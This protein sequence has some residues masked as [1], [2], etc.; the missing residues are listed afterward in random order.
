MDIGGEITMKKMLAVLASPRKNGNASKMLDIAVQKA[1]KCGYDVDYINLYDKNLAYCKG[2]MSCKKTAA[3]IIN[4]DIKE[5]ENQIKC[6]DLVIVSCPTYFANISAPLKNM[7]DRLVGVIMDDN[8]SIIPKPRLSPNQEYILMTT[9]NAPS[10]FDR[11]AGQSTGCIKAMKEFFHISGMKF[12]GK[13][14]FSGTRNKDTI[15]EPIIKKI[16]ALIN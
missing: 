2:C 3:C 7:F 14:V 5:I 1:E 9:C 6:C 13:V 10:P 4:D 8:S 16:N 11:I 12:R 15:P